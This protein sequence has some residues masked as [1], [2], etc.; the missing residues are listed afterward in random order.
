MSFRSPRIMGILNVTPNSFY[1]QGRTET[2]EDAIVRGLAMAH[3]GAD[4][5]DIGGESTRPGAQP[6]SPAEELARIEPVLC[7]LRKELPDIFLSVDTRHTAVAQRALA[8]GADIINDVSAT[9]PEEGIWATVAE[10]QAGY[11]VV[12][13]RG[14]PQTM[15][16]LTDY[17]EGVLPAVKHSLLQT[18]DA[19]LAAG[20]QAEQLVLDAGFGFAK[21]AEDSLRLLGATAEFASLPYPY[22]IAASRKRFIGA[23]TQRPDPADRGA[24]SLGAALWAVAQGAS[25][26]R[27]HDVEAT[28]DALAVFLAAK[29]AQGV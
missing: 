16:T 29:E 14:T 23:L 4:I 2:A 15:G 28:R 12:H 26:I 25:L 8:L 19:L 10:A 17:P 7:A 1:A 9:A 6:V 22:L 20:V 18:V 5:L 24:G 21:T 3:A 11:I 13:S 27:T